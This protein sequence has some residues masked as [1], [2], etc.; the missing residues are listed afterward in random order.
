[1]RAEP[2]QVICLPEAGG[3]VSYGASRSEAYRQAGLYVG[4][5]LK[6]E[7]PSDLP[8]VL[9]TKY[10]LVINLK[11]I[12]ALGLNLPPAFSGTRLTL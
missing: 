3:H 5:I 6:G 11:T 1:V 2:R 4:R 9:P 10:R 8:V 7:Q 12:K